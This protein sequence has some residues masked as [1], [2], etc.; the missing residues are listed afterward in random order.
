MI[1]G[2]RV[3]VAAVVVAAVAVGLTSAASGVGDVGAAGAIVDY[4][5]LRNERKSQHVATKGVKTSI[6]PPQ[7][8]TTTSVHTTQFVK[9][10]RDT[11]GGRNETW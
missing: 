1:R 7:T 9:R 4:L 10:V 6:F 5:Q 2:D 11:K 3:A 8:L